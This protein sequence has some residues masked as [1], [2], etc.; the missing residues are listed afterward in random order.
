MEETAQV[1]NLN[2]IFWTFQGEGKN[3]GRCALFVRLPYC[4]YS[5]PWCD[6]DY[7]SINFKLT[8]E[9]FKVWLDKQPANFAVVT[10]GEP[11]VNKHFGI[12]ITW[13]KKYG[14]EVAIESNGSKFHEANRFIDLLTISPKKHAPRHL[15]EFYI[16]PEYLNYAVKYPDKIEFKYVVEEGFDFSHVDKLV[17]GLKGVR[18]SLSP[19]FN[20][21]EDSMKRILEYCVKNPS[22]RYSLQTHKYLEIK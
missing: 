7:N 17:Q 14:F 1:I 18:I 3:V 6:T 21:L 20:I 9:E 2:D 8:E 15:P 22:V 4:N 13:L 11:T 10:G 5:C 16:D 19:E 12:I